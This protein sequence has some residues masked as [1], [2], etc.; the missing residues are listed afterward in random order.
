MTK[1]DRQPHDQSD[2]LEN[3]RRSII[4]PNAGT[5]PGAILPANRSPQHTRATEG[6]R[7]LVWYFPGANCTWVAVSS[8]A[9]WDVTRRNSNSRWREVELKKK[10]DRATGALA[11]R[12]PV[13][14][15]IIT[16]AWLA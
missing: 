12:Q 7:V 8:F 5:A 10:L 11:A 1:D 6:R 2:R 3:D 14:G 9:L 4:A 13:S 15:T 16:D